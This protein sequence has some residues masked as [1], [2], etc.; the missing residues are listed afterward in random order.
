MSSDPGP[1]ARKLASVV[2][3]AVGT[4]LAALDDEVTLVGRETPP[5]PADR[6]PD[7]LADAETVVGVVPRVHDALV[8]RL[9]DDADAIRGVVVVT[10]RARER[11]TGPARPVARSALAERDVDVY[12]HDGDAPVGVLLVDDR[13]LVGLFDG[14]DLAA[15]LVTDAPAVREWAAETCQRY[16]AAADPL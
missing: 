9:R 12:A 14:P 4:D 1:A 8:D 13:A 3:S 10:G 11:L 6:V 5:S 15:V 16:R 2:E 7:V